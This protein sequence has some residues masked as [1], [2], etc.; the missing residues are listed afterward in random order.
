MWLN[1]LLVGSYP[2]YGP[3]QI[4]QRNLNNPLEWFYDVEFMTDGKKRKEFGVPS[5][6]LQFI[7]V[8]EG[9]KKP[10]RGQ[11]TCLALSITLCFIFLF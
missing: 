8:D 10:K 5:W 3:P 4:L 6:F 9:V 2:E 1:L 7:D 11:N